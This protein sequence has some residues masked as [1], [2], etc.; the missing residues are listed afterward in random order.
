MSISSQSVAWSSAAPP[1]EVGLRIRI[2]SETRFILLWI[3][4][5][6]PLGLALH[7]SS[8]VATIHGLGTLAVAAW[9]GLRGRPHHALYLAGY[10][11]SCEVLWRMSHARVPWEAGKYGTVMVL[12]LILLRRIDRFRLPWA[13]VLFFAL[14]LP[15]AVLTMVHPAIESV[16]EQISFNLSGCFAL[17]VTAAYCAAFR[18]DRRQ[19][20]RLILVTLGP[21]IGIAAVTAVGTYA[22]GPVDFG[23]ESNYATSGGYG[24]NQVS[25]VLGLGAMLAFLLLSTSRAR[26]PLRGLLFTIA[27]ALAVQSAMTF[28]RGGLYGAAVGV[29]MALL[30]LTRDPRT[31]A[32][33]IGGAGLL[34]LLAQFILL[35][36]MDRFT[37]GALTD[38]FSQTQTTGRGDLMVADFH[39]F[40]EHPLLGVGPGVAKHMRE[41]DLH[42]AASHT[43]VTRLLAEHGSLGLIALGLL[44]WMAARAFLFARSPVEQAL[45]LAFAAWGASTMLHAGMRVAA[46]AFVFGLAMATAGMAEE[47]YSARRTARGGIRPQYQ[48]HGGTRGAGGARW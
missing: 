12:G 38:R 11:V 27:A 30:V 5:H 4:A 9:V 45:V 7:A 29:S 14:L 36:R 42:N 22:S 31:R 24:P 44:A 47:R 37:G 1:R 20:S 13:P 3:A 21:L 16:R 17:A 19:M 26:A 33:I 8:A 25:T 35:P 46:P 15:S 28:S 32:K 6:V 18:F 40:L 41:A 2:S 48:P 39:L 34:F 43:E 23:T 10:I